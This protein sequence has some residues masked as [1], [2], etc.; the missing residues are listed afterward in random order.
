MGNEQRP[1]SRLSQAPILHLPIKPFCFDSE[2]IV[3]DTGRSYTPLT[4]FLWEETSC[5]AM[6][7]HHRQD[8]D[9]DKYPLLPP[10]QASFTAPF[11]S[12]SLLPLVDVQLPYCCVNFSWEVSKCLFTPDRIP[13]THK[14]NSKNFPSK[15][16]LVNAEVQLGLVIETHEG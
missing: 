4:Q 7:R 6:V 11:S 8:T 15:Y 5:K 10:L 9:S 16:S 13:H 12:L 2:A 14:K 3:N 1:K